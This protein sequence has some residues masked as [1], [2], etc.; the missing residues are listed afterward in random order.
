MMVPG[1]Q[2]CGLGIENGI[3]MF[4][5]TNSV[6]A[7]IPRAKSEAKVSLYSKQS[8]EDRNTAFHVFSK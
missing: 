1:T 4:K 6:N 8:R 7:V 5:Y 2:P 3:N